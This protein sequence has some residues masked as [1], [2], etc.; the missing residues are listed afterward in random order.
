MKYY[1][2]FRENIYFYF[3]III[4]FALAREYVSYSLQNNGHTKEKMQ[5]H[6]DIKLFYVKKKKN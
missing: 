5:Y 1:Y 6:A 4:R 2:L 3:F